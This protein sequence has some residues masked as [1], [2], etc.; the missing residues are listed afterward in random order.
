MKNENVCNDCAYYDITT[1]ECSEHN[2]LKHPTESA[3]DK[4]RL[5]YVP[6]D[7]ECC[8][9]CSHCCRIEKWDFSHGGCEYTKLDGHAC[10]A[11]SN[12]GLVIWE[13]GS[14]INTGIC[15]CFKPKERKISK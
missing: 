9:N 5:D 1:C 10:T 4:F 7:D 12:E 8:A 6:S 14:N 13:Y 3:C 15:E 2:T 11:F